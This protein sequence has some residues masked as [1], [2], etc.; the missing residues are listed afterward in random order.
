[1]EHID[2]SMTAIK[3]A[4]AQPPL[5]AQECPNLEDCKGFC[6]QCEYF[7]AE[8]GMTE[9]PAAQPAQE[10]VDNDFFKSLANKKQSPDQRPW[11]G[12]TD[13]EAQ[14]LYDNCRTPSNLID[15]VEARLK[16]KNT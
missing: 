6:F 15:M 4:L 2:D 16:E 13:E 10:P 9:Y 14:W 3:E 8:T 7:N 5:P 11:V 12:L 1:V